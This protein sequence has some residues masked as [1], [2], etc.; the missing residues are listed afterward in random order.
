MS[1]FKVGDKVRVTY[2]WACG[3]VGTIKRYVDN[4][5]FVMKANEKPNHSYYEDESDDWCFHSADDLVELVIEQPLREF[6]VIRR[7]GAETIAEL[8]H[9]REV[10]KSARATCAPSD[11][12]DFETGAKLAFDRL[13]FSTFFLTALA[14]PSCQTSPQQQPALRPQYRLLCCEGKAV[15]R[16]FPLS[17][18]DTEHKTT[19][20][21]L[22]AAPPRAPLALLLRVRGGGR[23]EFPPLCAVFLLLLAQRIRPSINCS[24]VLFLSVRAVKIH[25]HFFVKQ[26][27]ER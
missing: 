16:R 27:A 4:G 12:F 7:S 25:V 26:I 10:I 1:K 21:R 11:T 17:I 9:D 13:S 18:S 22:S 20:L 23:V 14:P 19:C 5:R 8:R 2:G 24:C 6:I 3:T 15:L